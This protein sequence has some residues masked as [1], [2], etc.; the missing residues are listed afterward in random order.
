[1]S[2]PGSWMWDSLSSFIESGYFQVNLFVFWYPEIEEILSTDLVPGDTMLIPSNGTIMPCDA[3]LLSGTCI[4]NESMLTGKGN[5][6]H[7]AA[8]LKVLVYT[9]VHAY[10]QYV[11][12]EVDVYFVWNVYVLKIRHILKYYVLVSCLSATA[13]WYYLETPKM[14][15]GFLLKRF[16][17][18]SLS[19]CLF[20]WCSQCRWSSEAY[21]FRKFLPKF[22][23]F[24]QK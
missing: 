2:P 5:L 21:V 11:L 20:R 18:D 15:D 9:C 22:F 7:S 6:I 10:L 12:A 3:V 1:M 23:S 17:L 24:F 16:L 14:S 13:T 19:S 8:W 4:V